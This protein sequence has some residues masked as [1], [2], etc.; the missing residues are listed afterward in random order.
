MAKKDD[1]TNV[2]KR[3]VLIV[4]EK[5][6]VGKSVKARALIDQLRAEGIKL[7]AFDADGSI[8]A[9]VRVQGTRDEGGRLVPKQDPTKGVGYYNV[10]DDADR[11]KL[12]D[13]IISGHDIFV[14]D[15]AGGSLADLTR[16]VD[17]GEGLDGLVAAFGEHGYRLTIVH[18]ISPEIGSA[19]SVA[20]WIDLVGDRVDHIAVRNG[21]WGK[22]DA[23]FPFWV[24]FVDGKGNSKGGKTRD[25]FLALGGVEIELPAVPTGTYAKV[26]AENMSFS[27][28]AADT[29][30][31]ITERAHI[32]K[33]RRDY[34]AA[35]EPARQLLGL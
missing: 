9:L 34:A 12:L 27:A 21:R 35:L 31:T 16:I 17:G 2:L 26:D 11:N 10:R 4:S 3:V 6:G 28:A 15:L 23:D 25:K 14:H 30:L 20:R 8:G 29:S 18:V 33:F 32:A 7:A 1:L 19:Q 5:G 13:V 24:G 22:S